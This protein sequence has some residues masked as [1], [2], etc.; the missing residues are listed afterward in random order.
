MMRTQFFAAKMLLLILPLGACGGSGSQGPLDISIA[1]FETGVFV[2]APVR[3]M[4]Y[5]SSFSGQT[6]GSGEFLYSPGDTVRF[7]LGRY[8]F[9]A[10]PAAPVVTIVDLFDSGMIDRRVI[11][12][13]RVLQSLDLNDV[14]TDLLE[15]PDLDDLDLRDLNFDQAPDD[16]AADLLAR[17]VV[18]VVRDD[19]VSAEDAY[20]HLSRSFADLERP[21]PA[22]AAEGDTDG[23]GLDD[24]IDGDDDGDG[25]VDLNGGNPLPELEDPPERAVLEADESAPTGTGFIQN[26]SEEFRDSTT[27]SD[28]DGIFD[29][30]DFLPNSQAESRY[31]DV[32]GID[33]G[34]CGTPDTACA[35][36]AY[37]ASLAEPGNRIAI[38][39]GDYF[40]SGINITT[41]MLTI[42]GVGQTSTR[43]VGSQGASGESLI[44]IAP[45]LRVLITGLTLEQASGQST[46]A[47]I[48]VDSGELYMREMQVRQN[49]SGSVA[50]SAINSIDSLLSI[51]EVGFF[52]NLGR[53]IVAENSLTEINLSEFADNA[54]TDITVSGGISVF[55]RN[56]HVENLST[57]IEVLNPSGAV[58]IENSTFFRNPIALSLPAE[59]TVVADH[60]SIRGVATRSVA[61]VG[62]QLELNNSY[63]VDADCTGALLGGVGNFIDGDSCGA[64]TAFRTVGSAAD[65]ASSL[66]SQADVPRYLPLSGDS[67]AVDAVACFP[68]IQI[69]HPGNPRPAGMLCDAGAHEV[70]TAP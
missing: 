61:V 20:N 32:V 55:T 36:I 24:L 15:I 11:N 29:H 25:I 12:L 17:T 34:D 16:F 64:D 53:S 68:G 59:G 33:Q 30:I 42:R 66:T 21:L 41:D 70:Q 13:A 39:G 65:L 37:A 69:D 14:T 56:T 6:N 49:N 18:A 62:D 57:A 45:G 22:L 50:G 7:E 31:V 43:I 63:I 10:V 4:S 46:G 48:S 19:M 51:Q 60:I 9:D 67:P 35:T 58:I 27:D 2:D 26:T 1:D 44:S 8:E 40:E 23:D 3:G 28:G 47:V 54:G 38:Q 5:R 52:D